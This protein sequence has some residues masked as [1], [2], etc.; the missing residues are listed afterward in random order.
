MTD[1]TAKIRGK[2]LDTTGVTESMAADLFN[3]VGTHF[4]A[5]VDLQVVDTHG[6][7]I[8]GKR[9][10]EIVIDALEPAT[11]EDIAEHLRELTRTLY[12][13]RGVGHQP[14]LP[15]H[16]EPT[17][18]GVMNAGAKHRPHPFLPVNAGEDDNP[19]CDVCGSL[20][21]APVHSTQDTLPNGDADDEPDE[22]LEDDEDEGY[23][24][25]DVPEDDN[26]EDLEDLYDDED[27]RTDLTPTTSNPFMSPAG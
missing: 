20:E 9:G 8:K 15:G 17:V 10:V 23:D 14:M 27:E 26:L 13:N 7:D 6:P 22:D 4:M 12:Y 24:D 19:I 25:S 2:G 11:T 1:T 21:T 18:E 16:D 5:I 3:K